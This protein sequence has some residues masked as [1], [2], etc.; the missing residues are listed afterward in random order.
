VL[1][2]QNI[3]EQYLYRLLPQGVVNLD[4]RKLIEAVVGGYQDR[5]SD[6][7][8]YASNLNELVKPDAQ[9]PQL[10]F[11]VVLATFEGPVGQIITRSLNFQ[12]N[13]PDLDDTEALT[14]WAADQL[15]LDDPT[16][17]QSVVAGTDALRLVDIDSISLLAGNVGAILY[18]GLHDNES[19]DQARRTRQQLLESHFPRLRIK[20]TAD[21]FE[22]L[23]RVLGFD[24]VAMTPLWSR[25]V[26]RLP[27]D[28][29]N[30]LNAEDF[31]AR[32]EQ[33]P[34]A[35]L[36]DQRYN[37][38]DFSDGE[39]YTWN[40]GPLSEDP[41]SANF[42]PRAVNNR[43]PFVKLIQLG[44]VARPAIGRY[45]LSGGQSN[46]V[47]SVLLNS[48]TTTSNLR[49]DGLAAGASMN[50]MKLNVIDFSGT[51]VG[52]EV[53]AKLSAVKYRSSYFDLKATMKSVGTEPIQANPDLE[54]QPSLDPDGTAVVPFRPWIGGSVTQQVQTYPTVD[55]GS[56]T[57]VEARTQATGN[58][59]QMSRAE[60][61]NALSTSNNLDSMKAA[62]RRIRTRSVGVSVRDDAK[63]AAYQ[64]DTVL[65]TANSIG[66][67]SGFVSNAPKEPKRVSFQAIVGDF[68]ATTYV[69]LVNDGTVTITGG[70]FF[71]IYRLT[72]DYYSIAVFPGPFSGGGQMV[73]NFVALQGTNIRAEPT[74][75]QKADGTIAYQRNPE[76]QVNFSGSNISLYDEMPWR[77]D[78]LIAGHHVD[79][80]FYVP[81]EPDLDYKEATVPYRVLALSGRQYEVAVLDAVQKYQPF[82]FKII[83]NQE[84]DP[85]TG[86]PTATTY[87]RLLLAENES[88][89]QFH[90]LLIDKAIVSTQYWSPAKRSNIVQWA[91]FNEHPLDDVE[92]YAR[93]ATSV[94]AEINHANRLWDSTRGWY[95]RLDQGNTV[96]IDSPTGLGFTF[97][98]A[99]WLKPDSTPPIGTTYTEILNVGGFVS[100]EITDNASAS[101]TFIRL[102]AM[103]S[104][105]LAEIGTFALDSVWQIV[106]IRRDG[107]SFSF[108]LGT[109]A[110]SI[111]WQNFTFTDLDEVTSSKLTLSCG[112]RSYGVHDYTAWDTRKTDGEFELIRNPNPIK[113]SVAYP[114][115]WV[116]S[117]SR[118]NRY[119]FKLV[120]S[121]FAYPG[122]SDLRQAR[123]VPA[124]AQRYS[125]FGLYEGDPRFKIVGLGDGNPV[126]PAYPL[127]FRGP[128]IEGAGRTLVA[129]SYTPLPGYT[130]MW[131]TI[132][133]RIVRVS[134]PFNSTGGVVT[135]PTTLS[136]PWPQN[137]LG[138]PAQDRAYIEGDDGYVYKIF[139]DDLGSG[140]VLKAERVL[141]ERRGG[142]EVPVLQP[143]DAHSVLATTGKRLSVSVVGTNY[144]VYEA[145]DASQTWT[146]PPLYLYR[147]TQV[148]VDAFSDAF[149]R[150]ANPN[151]FGQGLGT[152]ALSGDGELEFTNSE[153]LPIGT[154]QL[155]FDIG[156]IGTVDD[157]FS[158]FSTVVSLV[159]GSGSVIAQETQVL[160]QNGTGTDPRGRV[161]FNIELDQILAGPWL[162]TV[163]WNNAL[164]VP[165]KGQKR[166]LAIYGYEFRLISPALYQITLNPLTMTAVNISD[167]STVRPGGLVAKINS[168]GTIASIDHEALQFPERS[169]WP[170]SNLLTTSSWMRR[171][172][173][174]VVNPKVEP[175][176][177]NPA[178]PTVTALSFVDVSTGT[179][180]AYYNY[181]D[182]VRVQG[183]V[184]NGTNA[185]AYVWRFWD[186]S[187][188]T[189]KTTAVEKVVSPG[190]GNVNGTVTMTVVDSIGNSS[191]RSTIVPINHPPVVS[192][193]V[194]QNVGI[195]P[196]YG[197]IVATT[198][199]PDGDSVTMKWLEN[200]TQIATGLDLNY[201]ATRQTTLIARATD[202]RG[203]VTDTRVSFSGN[204]R[205]APIVSPIIRA[206][207]GRISNTNEMDFAVYALNPNTGGLLTFRWTF[208]N[209]SIPSLYRSGYTDAGAP[210]GDNVKDFNYSVVDNSVNPLY[211]GDA[212][213]L[214]GSPG[215]I[216]TPSPGVNGLSS[217]RPPGYYDFKLSFVIPAGTD[218][219]TV[220][221]NVTGQA[222]S[223]ADIYLNDNF[224]I[225]HGFD[226]GITKSFTLDPSNAT[227]VTGENVLIFRVVN[228][229]NA[230][231][232]LSVTSISGTFATNG[233]T[234]HVANSNVYFNQATK[235]LAG[236]TAGEK[237]VQV[238]VTD[239][240]GYT[241]TVQT[242]ITLVQNTPPTIVAITTPSA[243][244]LAGTS[245]PYS[246]QVQDVDLDQVSYVWNFTSPRPLQL[247]GGNVK[248]PTEVGDTGSNIEGTLTV[249]DGNG[250]STSAPIP[251]VTIASSFL[252]PITLSVAPGFYQSGFVQQI[253]TQDTDVN[254]R[255]TLDGTDIF[256]A[257]DGQEYLGPFLIS[258]PE[259]NTGS[260]VLKVRGFKAS[261]APTELIT[262][263]YTF[264]DPNTVGTASDPNVG[265]GGAQVAVVTIQSKGDT[266]ITTASG[267]NIPG[268]DGTITVSPQSTVPE[269]NLNDDASLPFAPLPPPGSG[270]SRGT[271]QTNYV[272][273]KLK[274]P[275]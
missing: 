56:R 176:P 188:E 116:E 196:Y 158:G 50:G 184:T 79:D 99:F 133:G 26:P 197:S 128:Y 145:N 52:L 202:S 240:D 243:G 141:Q 203:G 263:N 173:L 91:P 178:V 150:W 259:G 95:L 266:T 113:S 42:W 122:K 118:D 55:V 168:Y 221:V 111:T 160:L 125:G 9:L 61:D 171:Q 72:D 19:A 216:V 186:S 35:T 25:L 80:D 71:G 66:T 47:P 51:A 94:E 15:K 172:N 236:S 21:S 78:Q 268:D 13:M 38:N 68:K 256:Q 258:P 119:V 205:Q 75:Q 30:S 245:V 102:K 27:S 167:T 193:A 58:A 74:F 155:T 138:N 164:A 135:T 148:Y 154:F 2:A 140:P 88:G 12:P 46:V 124:Y 32:P 85:I 29:G 97:S 210:L 179:N 131:G 274:S 89:E 169:D 217:I 37:P 226:F 59:V 43:N 194:S 246:A 181:G 195:F 23:G 156:N 86:D 228:L 100:V 107:D 120:D 5:I 212:Y 76:D 192:L 117:L 219:G 242:A 40:S 70:D 98:F 108:G 247:L 214:T 251:V 269:I 92:P 211:N 200:G 232:F 93:Y 130:E 222:S 82:R 237:L 81:A 127:G 109:D 69:D 250:G 65:F 147:Q 201:L 53:T 134:P 206:D 235:A 123:D 185:Q 3:P 213:S 84:V 8:S 175:D 62:T 264:Y 28:P 262:A 233:V 182:K 207:L 218:L 166:Q 20:G 36:P 142:S 225:S 163:E 104:G 174:R 110:A 255:Y 22:L 10:G 224:A 183:T 45:V 83:Q 257:T 1:P 57:V 73:A 63:F 220:N 44:D 227:F 191:Q 17:I 139:A 231:S 137:T 87:D 121:G 271:G 198:S 39:F 249:N 170:L 48:G 115:T 238:V 6:L 143:T 161:S 4:T 41:N 126:Q 96:E 189:T 275:I 177:A 31:N 136:N 64:G 157:N 24:S 267:A 60:F 261:Y 151:S 239:L 187:V 114:S 272:F 14:Q 103:R 244:A 132:P 208:W 67:Y 146:T 190:V 54:A 253:D 252:K 209:N 229:T 204:P 153:T 152:P 165:R 215:V 241:T 16:K 265:T 248:Y 106:A 234:T 270:A 254:I 77:R 260:V 230:P 149:D 34:S 159:N 112:A 18:P 49:A 33:T 90:V 180:K 273:V 7:R 11:N 105:A 144:Q 101:N 223:Y 162:M 129:G 199:D